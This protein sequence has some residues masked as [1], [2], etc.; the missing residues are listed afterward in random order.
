MRAFSPRNARGAFDFSEPDHRP[1]L[2]LEQRIRRFVALI[3][4]VN[5]ILLILF[6]TSILQPSVER[7]EQSLLFDDLE[8]VE[9]AIEQESASLDLKCREWSAWDDPYELIEKP[10]SPEL[11]QFVADNLVDEYFAAGQIALMGMIDR[12]GNIVWGEIHGPNGRL[13]EP[14][15]DLREFFG[16]DPSAFFDFR[17]TTDRYSGVV[18]TRLGPMI[19]ASRP[20][21]N[22]KFEGPIRGAFIMGKF[23]DGRL[24]ARLSE[25]TRVLFRGWN[26]GSQHDGS[27][28]P[29]GLRAG[30]RS[31]DVRDGQ[32][33]DAYTAIAD[34]RGE[35]VYVAHAII[36]RTVQLQ[37]ERFFLLMHGSVIGVSVAVFLAF[38]FVLRRQVVRPIVEMKGAMHSLGESKDVTHRL[39]SEDPTE[40]GLLAGDIHRLLERTTRDMD[41]MRMTEDA[42][43]RNEHILRLMAERTPSGFLLVD[44]A[45]GSVLYHNRL[46]CEIWAGSAY[47]A[48]SNLCEP[49][50]TELRDRVGAT[51][52]DAGVARVFADTLLDA[53][54]DRVIDEEWGL[55]DGRTVKTYSTLLQSGD[56]VLI[57]RYYVFDDITAQKCVEVELVRRG[58]LLEAVATASNLLISSSDHHAA[59]SDALAVLGTAIEAERVEICEILSSVTATSPVVERRHRWIA[60][61]DVGGEEGSREDRMGEID[62][63]ATIDALGDGRV[64]RTGS[65]GRAEEWS[66]ACVILVPVHVDAR[67]WG[68]IRFDLMKGESTRIEEDDAILLVAA[69]SI[70]A[71]IA[72]KAYEKKLV[73]TVSELER[74]NRLMRGRENRVLELKAV[75]NELHLR[76][77]ERPR[78]TVPESYYGAEDRRVS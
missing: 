8:R 55:T 9:N 22:G 71:D 32:T 1:K 27:G 37:A 53:G 70:G 39:S 54:D 31:F 38:G 44:G 28:D 45:G 74:M 64:I 4:G 52:Q 7:L 65:G 46:F 66:E 3:L 49:T 58:L 10:E 12:S 77:G 76:L 15:A 48:E 59:M 29:A 50:L 11:A 2:P 72:R 21:L 68:F 34:D 42:L 41:F 63:R 69:G 40:I 57:G 20:Q 25:Q 17:N 56:G 61:E 26:A 16:R 23:L 43:R 78:Y 73:E 24:T 6:Q 60:H 47:D 75:I 5:V 18:G 67:L 36:P 35:P 51:L 30:E 14:L 62:L 13:I 33:I 19:L